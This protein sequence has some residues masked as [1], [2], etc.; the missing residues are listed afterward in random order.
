MLQDIN[1]IS[2]FIDKTQQK[3]YIIRDMS[4]PR[5]LFV[6]VLDANKFKVSKSRLKYISP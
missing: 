1:E 2:D 4:K 5:V 3:L 6:T